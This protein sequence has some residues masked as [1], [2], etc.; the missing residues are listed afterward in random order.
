[1][2]QKIRRQRE[3]NG[4]L[5]EL[6]EGEANDIKEERDGK[7]KEEQLEDDD[8]HNDS[9]III[10][11]LPV[12]IIELNHEHPSDPYPQNNPE[13]FHFA[14]KERGL[15]KRVSGPGRHRLINSGASVQ[16]QGCWL[17]SP[18]ISSYLNG[19]KYLLCPP[20]FKWSIPSSNLHLC[21]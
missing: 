16:I 4:R 14:D 13:K 8:G 2:S 3:G 6:S 9:T 15:G 10:T 20:M 11:A 19:R 7:R 18:L 17:L 21:V 5:E 12:P 1:M